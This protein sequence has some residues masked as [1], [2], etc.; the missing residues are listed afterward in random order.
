MWAEPFFRNYIPGD[1]KTSVKMT[2]LIHILFRSKYFN[3]KVTV[4]SQSIPTLNWIQSFLDQHNKKYSDVRRQMK[5]LRIDGSTPAATRSDNIKR[6]N[7]KRND[8][9]V[10]LVS[11]KAG[12]E[13]INLIG[14]NRVVLFDVSWNPCHDHQAMCRSHRLGQDKD[15]YVYRLISCESLEKKIFD[16]QLHKEGMSKRVIDDTAIERRLTKGELQDIFDCTHDNDPHIV[17]LIIIFIG[18]RSS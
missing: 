5:Y 7:D 3:E 4:F 13:G 16:L 1:Y 11:T 14:G 8:I 9:F 2:V 10:M 17:Y 6:F 15:V 12:G 18:I